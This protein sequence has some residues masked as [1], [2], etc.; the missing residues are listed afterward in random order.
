MGRHISAQRGGKT[1]RL[2]AKCATCVTDEFLWLNRARNISIGAEQCHIELSDPTRRP[3]KLL[4]H[5]AC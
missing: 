2:G 5:S 3:L 4:L 1:A